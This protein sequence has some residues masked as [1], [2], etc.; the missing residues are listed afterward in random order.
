MEPPPACCRTD[1]GVL[2]LPR[3]S[4]IPGDLQR[5]SGVGDILGRLK[6]LIL[7]LLS[8]TGGVREPE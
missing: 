6:Q 7:E 1:M 5:S 3:G 4:S 2:E 8:A